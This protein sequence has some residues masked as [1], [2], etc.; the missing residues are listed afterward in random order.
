MIL[1][2][3]SSSRFWTR[4]GIHQHCKKKILLDVFFPNGHWSQIY[5]HGKFRSFMGCT[6]FFASDLLITPNRGHV[7]TPEKVTN[8][9]P[10]GRSRF[11]SP[12]GWKATYQSMPPDFR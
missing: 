6:S 2:L 5:D 10:S 1:H 11:R 12:H 7:F 8:K 4:L 9:T 3:P